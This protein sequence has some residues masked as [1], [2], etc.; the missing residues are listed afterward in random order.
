MPRQEPQGAAEKLL[1][2]SSRRT[3]GAWQ[4]APTA[5]TGGRPRRRRLVQRVPGRPQASGIDSA[6]AAIVSADFGSDSGVGLWQWNASP[7]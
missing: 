2:R 6:F 5:R 3:A 4:I 1:Q 7:R